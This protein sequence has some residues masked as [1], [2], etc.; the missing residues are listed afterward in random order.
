MKVI[1]CF[2]V[3]FFFG[4]PECIKSM[5]V[6]MYVLLLLLLLFN[7]ANNFSR[8]LVWMPLTLT[9]SSYFNSTCGNFSLLLE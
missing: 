3:F 9:F 2:F 8:S 4:Q 7:V 5:Y 6:C 1:S